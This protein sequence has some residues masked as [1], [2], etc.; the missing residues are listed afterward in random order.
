VDMTRLAFEDV[1]R[2][3]PEAKTER[4]IE[5]AFFARARRQGNDTGYLTIAAAGSHAT[6][7]HWSHN[8]GQVRPG[9]LLLLDAGV[10]SNR[11]YT[12]DVTRTLPINGHFTPA[13]RRVYELVWQAQ[14][15]GFAAIR[16]GADFLA[17]NRAA[18]AVLASGLEA[19]GILP[20]SAEESLRSDQQLHQRYTLHGVSHMLGL[21]VHDCAHARQES[22]PEGR[23]EVGMV[24]TVEPGLYFQPHDGTVPPE[25][26]GIG[27]RIEDDVVVTKDGCQVLSAGLPSHPDQVEAWM[28]AIWAERK[29]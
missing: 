2:A 25:L 6:I 7:L 19:M 24:L 4:D 9:E 20:V 8:T 12:A 1:V 11:Y 23:L 14:Q 21:D 22:Y 3:L 17:P 27:V 13:Q 5:V 28:A 18:Q 26:R 10:E 16:P 15:A 29:S